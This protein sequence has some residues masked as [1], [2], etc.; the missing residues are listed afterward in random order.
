MEAAELSN[1]WLTRFC[2]QRALG[3]VYVIAFLIVIN[4]FQ[5]L[6]GEN[7]IMPARLFLKRAEFWDAPSL[8]WIH[9]SDHF[10]SMIAW[11]GLVLS[12]FAVTGLSDIF[13]IYVSAAVWALLWVLYLSFV[14]IGQT[15]YSF[16][17]ETLLL[18][19]GFL[20]IFLGSSNVSP[21]VI[22]I[23]LLRWV[24]FRVMF[25]AGLIKLRGDECWRNLTCMYYHYETQPLPNPL[26]WYF[27]R[28]PPLLHKGSVLF[29]HFVELVAPWGV[30]VPAGAVAACAGAFIFIFQ[31]ILILSG[32]LS[33]LN[34]IT[35][36]LCIPCFDDKILSHIIPIKS[37]ETLPIAGPYQGIVMAVAAVLLLLSIQ[38][39]VNLLS[40]RQI[41]NTSFEPL[42]LVNT[43]G[44]F[45]SITRERMEV[46]I[47]GTDEK[48][49]T[50]L[51]QWK[52]YEFKGKPGD[53][54]RPPCI[55]SPY[56]WKLDWQMWFAAMS[57]YRYHPWIL[58]LTAKLL[59]GDR[60]VSKLLA[61]NPF[62]DSPPKFIRAEL[63][64]YHFTGAEEK[65]RT[66]NWWWRRRVG[67]Y[68][69]PLSL[70]NPSFQEALR[71]E[72]WN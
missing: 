34:Y 43:Y 35:L 15:F 50:P 64:E 28:F 60:A 48:I 7:G 9:C 58:N 39:V 38:P 6:L 41:M 36:V 18:E 1:Y 13:G 26:S 20:A 27:H 40:S 22:I 25:G 8:F 62:S 47:E 23:W 14:N 52:P 3:F 49:V 2:F 61:E 59:K 32:N 69:P 68:L 30:F 63:Y 33:W 57:D 67:E 4:Q 24:L 44:A 37:I 53:P 56:H 12:F 11:L 42:H 5:P 16:G 65:T 51:T 54:K 10:I 19:T 55:V 29:N 45:G 66:G 17:W 46:I 72:E 70:D 31:V 21:P 71:Q